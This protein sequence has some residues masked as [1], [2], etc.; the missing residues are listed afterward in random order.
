[1]AAD[2]MGQTSG[3]GLAVWGGMRRPGVLIIVENLPLPFDRRVW[4]EARALRD[5]GH[6]VSIICPR[7]KGYTS[8]YEMLDGIAIYR[9]PLPAEA[10]GALG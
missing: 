5:A 2:D 4:M 8:P 10:I 9:H 1:M 6:T 7:G 3:D